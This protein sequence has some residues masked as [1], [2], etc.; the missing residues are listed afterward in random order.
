MK[1]PY[2]LL[3]PKQLK[4]AAHTFL[5][6]GESLNRFFPFLERNLRQAKF[7][8]AAKEYLAMCFVA[9]ALFFLFSCGFISIILFLALIDHWLLLAIA[10]SLLLSSF[11]FFQQMY[12]P[13]LFVNRRIRD[14]ERNILAALQNILIQINSGIPLFDT[15][16]NI[17]KGGYGEVSNEFSQAVREINTGKSQ[18]ETLEDMAATNPSLLFRRGIWQ[19]VNGMKSGANLSSVLEE[20]INLLSEE[21]LLQIQKY[22]SQLNPLAMFY[23]LVV[24][25]GPSLGMTFLVI[26]SSFIALS[27][28]VTKI[29]FWGLYGMVFFFQIMFIGVIKS[30]RPNLLGD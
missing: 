29:V 23:M 17:A 19:L 11:V 14:I 4:T 26:L 22:G 3:A 30:R 1:I 15:M 20:I 13:K 2:S 16:V 18:T 6:I 21:Q 8:I 12:Y 25:I 7:S 10:A 24:V 27:D 5:G 9:T 28:A